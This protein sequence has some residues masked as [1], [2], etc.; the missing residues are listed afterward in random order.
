MSVWKSPVFYFGILLLA[1]VGG[2]MVAPYVVDWNSYKDNLEAYGRRLTGRNVEIGGDV[3]IRLFPWPRLTAQQVA[4]GNPEGIDGAPL[5]HSEGLTLSLQLGG[6]L[7]GNLN[8]ES[9]ELLEP[10]V[11]LLRT[12]EGAVNWM[13]VPDEDLRRSTLL[14]NVRLDQITLVNGSVRLD[15]RRQGLVADLSTID[16]DMSADAIEG[17]WRLKGTGSWREMPVGITFSSGAYDDK[18]PFRFGLRLTPGDPS[19]PVFSIDGGL[20]D[21]AFDGD[22]SVLPQAAEGQ[23][24]SVEGGLKPLA[25]RAKLRATADR[26]DLS[27]IKITPADARDSGTLVE[28]TAGLDLGTAMTGEITLKAPRVN[29]D[30]MLGS[31]ALSAWRS[32]GVLALSHA[33]LRN[34]PDKLDVRFGLDVTVLTAGGETM[35]DVRLVAHVTPDGIAIENAR[36]GLPGRS[37][38]RLTDG[39]VARKDGATELSGVLAFESSD[40]RALA[41]WALP[42][43]KAGFDTWW[44]G[45]RGRLKMQGNLAW[46]PSLMSLGDVR[47]ELEGLPGT[48]E[49]VLRQGQVPSLLMR[50]TTAVLD[51]DSL[52]SGGGAGLRGHAFDLLD[53]LNPALSGAGTLEKHLVLDA[54]AVTLN[55]VRAQDVALD[56]GTSQSGFEIKAFDIGSVGGA[57][58]KAEGL[59]L[60]KAEGPSG[61]VTATLVADD[62]RGFLRLLGLS[63]RNAQW[64]QGLG[65]SDVTFTF[66]ARPD[67]NGA[68]LTY[69][70]SGSASPFRMSFTGGITELERGSDA[71]VSL[72]GTVDAPDAARLLAV[73]GLESKAV[74]PSAGKVALSFSGSKGGGFASKIEAQAYGARLSFDGSLKPAEAYSGMSGA[75]SLFAD[76]VGPLLRALGVPRTDERG[77]PVRLAFKVTPKDGGLAINDVVGDHAGLALAGEASFDKDGKLAADFNIGETSLPRLLALTFMPWRG[78]EMDAAT[79]FAGPGDLLFDGEIW[80]RPR[81]LAMPFGTQL[82]ETAVGITLGETRRFA[83]LAPTMPELEFDVEV[84]ARD[85]GFD[86]KAKG[87]LPV[88]VAQVL[89]ARDGTVLGTGGLVVSG[90]LAGSGRSPAAVLTT[91]EGKG[92]YTLSGL[93]FSK[94][95]PEAFAAKFAGVKSADD[96]RAALEALEGDAGLKVESSGGSFSVSK[97]M[98]TSTPTRV[99]GI[100]TLSEMTATAD[101]GA[102]R[103]DLATAVTL[104]GRPELPPVTITYS[105]EAGAMERRSSSAALA[106]KLGHEFLARDLAELERLKTEQEK[107]AVAEEEQRLQDVAKFEAYQAQRAEIRMRQREL[108]VHA[109]S[110]A[111]RKAVAEAEFAAFVPLGDAMNRIELAKK[112]LV[113]GLKPRL[114]AFAAENARKAKI[115]EER[116]K[117][118]EEKARRAEE[119][120]LKAIEEEK[121]K[122]EALRLKALADEQAR[123]EA[124]RRK[125]EEDA[126]KAAAAQAK[127]EADAKALAEEQ[128]RAEAERKRLEDEARKKLEELPK[129]NMLP[130]PPVPQVPPKPACDNPLYC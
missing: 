67:P 31:E 9:V 86:A 10:K 83:L 38:M 61:D 49:V 45:S 51:L 42:E 76:D 117:A 79:S 82:K 52:L 5:I 15:D 92:A 126:A 96:L 27:E 77:G 118:L 110:R 46:T 26:A 106:S 58:V 71:R 18:E 14:S 127:A 19:L 72:E 4:I 66:N 97:G 121:A 68:I 22:V 75:A 40:L 39:K 90:E 23:K 17:P 2:L 114:A 116:K 6:L 53:I 62:P 44:K 103:V 119:A 100:G 57:R 50:L 41:G 89:T 60:S 36:A 13:L 63:E 98:L 113:L 109:A 122:A 115:E 8:V 73:A 25:L 65:Q 129:L 48:G 54:G 20:K 99:S 78:A 94:L 81:S 69:A 101:L 56:V 55:G 91:L 123:I 74:A 85:G 64:T 105:G 16:A 80:L 1:V 130:E 12:A 33:M 24:G 30:T 95:A 34:L 3:E 29:L 32:G 104:T 43:R 84:T 111:A 21:S 125:A 124:A 87:K 102:L 11:T 88:D 47:Y 70:L 37:A 128:A 107:L 7:N 108:K 112:R 120:R 28:G 93:A 59:V 35:N